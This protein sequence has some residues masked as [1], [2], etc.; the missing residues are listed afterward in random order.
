MKNVIVPVGVP[1]AADPVTT[2]WSVTCAFTANGPVP[3]CGLV[4]VVV[5]ALL[6]VTHSLCLASLDPVYVVPE[7]V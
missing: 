3:G 6:T 2:A 7:G 5:G 4:T 1:S